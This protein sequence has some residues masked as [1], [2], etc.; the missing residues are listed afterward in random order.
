MTLICHCSEND[1]FVYCTLSASLK[2][3]HISICT[4]PIEIREE[5]RK[6]KFTKNV[7]QQTIGR[8]LRCQSLIFRHNRKNYKK[9]NSHL[10]R[11]RVMAVA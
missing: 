7:V 11:C 6:C 1:E 8:Q 9:H 4:F 10:F 5:Y 3:L 2:K